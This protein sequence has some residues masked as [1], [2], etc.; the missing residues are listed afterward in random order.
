MIR[1]LVWINGIGF[2]GLGIAGLMM[3]NF[4]VDVIGYQLMGTD[5]AIEVRA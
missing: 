1:A 5:A 2:L 4:L 3:P